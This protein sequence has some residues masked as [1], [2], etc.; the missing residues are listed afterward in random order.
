MSFRTLCTRWIALCLLS[1]SVLAASPDG[2][3]AVSHP[4]AAAAGA[5]ILAA[6]GNAVDAA[7]AVQFALNVVEPQSSGIGGGG[8][9]M[10]YLAKTKQTFI[11]DSRERAPAAARPDQFAPDGLPMPFALASTSGLAVGVPGTLRGID[12]ALTRW[13][14]MTLADTLAPAIDLAAHGFRVNRFLAADIA[15]DDGRTARYPET[16]ATFR[17]GGVPLAEG[18]W[19]VQP[20][21]AKTLRL[22]AAKGPDAF[23]RGPLARAIV[24]AQQR[25]RSELGAAGRGRMTLADLARYTVAIREPLVG[26]YRGWTL[27]TMPPPSSGGLTLLEMLGLLER[28]PLGDAA[29]GYGFGSPKTLHVMIEAMR[30]AFADRAVWIGDDD[31]APVP[32]RGLLHPEYLARRAAL[33]RTDHRMDTP[34]A[35]DPTPWDATAAPPRTTRARAESP[36]TTHFAIVDRWGNMVSYTTTIEYTWGT[37]ITVPGYGFLLNNELT[38]FNFLPS[39][40]AAAGNPGANDVAP[41]KRPRSSMAPT[42]LFKNGLPVAAY[43]SPGGAT[44]INSVLNVTL[45]LVDHGMT[46]QQAI[47]APRLSVTDASGRIS[48]EGGP[49][50]MQ[51]RF[52]IAAQDALRG[53]GHAGLGEAGT[54]GCRATIGS[55]QAVFVD[56]VNGAHRGAAD[57][58]REGTVVR[59]RRGGPGL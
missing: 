12:T 16:A 8:F 53:L 23:Y 56:A 52:T 34:E 11:V 46:M 31:A 42:M 13:G 27:A 5:R 19:L 6:G 15:D 26:H 41:G 1:G 22:I 58:R 50:F 24:A 47:E 3:V 40:D 48:C 36:H 21:L 18:D 7:A 25:A 49:P 43:G 2:V 4:A 45:D 28:F 17:P 55:V 59:V 20:D 39:A 37:G 38:D 30:L 10:V 35:G 54:D 44:I 57:G 32:R 9:M 51:P 33:I 14:T 29:Q